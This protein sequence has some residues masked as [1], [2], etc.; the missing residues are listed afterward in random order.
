MKLKFKSKKLGITLSILC[1]LV[2]TAGYAIFYTILPFHL[3]VSY[4]R[5][6][7][8][9]SIQYKNASG[10]LLHEN[11]IKIE[12]I[13]IK[14]EYGQINFYG[15]QLALNNIKSGYNFSFKIPKINLQLLQR[16]I[17][18]ENIYGDY[19]YNGFHIY[20]N[21]EP[22]LWQDKDT[23][24]N[25]IDIV[26]KEKIKLVN[27]LPELVKFKVT[28]DFRSNQINGHVIASLNY[29][30]PNL[31]AKPT[32]ATTDKIIINGY[33][34]LNNFI[35][36]DS[37]FDIL[38]IKPILFVNT[39][40]AQLFGTPNIIVSVN[41]NKNNIL[42]NTNLAI[43]GDI[44]IASGLIKAKTATK[45][46]SSSDIEFINTTT[47]DNQTTDTLSQINLIKKLKISS[48]IRLRTAKNHINLRASGLTTKLNGE[49]DISYHNYNDLL[50][51]Q[52]E[53]DLIDGVYTLYGYPLKIKHGELLYSNNPLDNPNIK[54]IGERKI[55]VLT[56]TND[57][58]I[59][60]SKLSPNNNATVGIDISGT[61]NNPE[62]KL[63][64]SVPMSETDRITYL[65]FG[66]SNTNM[67]KA[68]G[69]ILLQTMSQLFDNDDD[70][71]KTLSSQLKDA[72]NIDDF[73]L[74]NKTVKNPINGQTME[75][76]SL[77]ISKRFFT[78]LLVSYGFSLTSP[79]NS[80]TAEYQIND[81]LSLAAKYDNGTTSSAD[82]IYRKETDKLL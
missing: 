71:Y 43:T 52:G 32:I 24:K 6:T 30:K 60:E 82:I 12:K 36:Q 55:K 23:F 34:N 75:Q 79:L 42:S 53:I 10:Y 39:Q 11:G 22:V 14:H 17:V 1:L 21:N 15:S 47:E 76:S 26:F 33:T 48:H 41:P 58:I 74:E 68:Q 73:S 40:E 61:L 77:V 35:P 70:E 9:A 78:H 51:A 7:Q 5:F 69:Q 50:L 2:L 38:S 59:P 65:L 3:A 54:L 37:Q 49:L 81:H 56:K 66:I 64:S 19:A 25:H 67:K 80:L 57:N 29:D 4:L 46:K 72:F 31:L 13:S 63:Y 18:L 27:F 45:L 16:K 8:D 28:A 44:L 20:Y 62:I